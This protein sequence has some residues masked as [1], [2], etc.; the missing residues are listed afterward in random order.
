WLTYVAITTYGYLSLV[1]SRAGLSLVDILTGSEQFRQLF[2]GADGYVAPIGERMVA[3]AGVALSLIGLPIGLYHFWHKF[4]HSAAAWLLAF[5]AVSYFAMLPLRLSSASWETGNRASVYFY[6]GLA[7]VLALAADRLW[8]D[9]QRV[10]TKYVTPMFGSGIAFALIFTIIFAGGV[11]AGRQPQLRL[12]QPFV[13]DAGETLIETQGVSAARWMQETVG[14]NHTI[15]SDEVNGRLMLA[16]AEQAGYVGR[17]PYVR[18]ILR[19]PSF[20]PLQLGVMQ[21]WD[22]EYAVVDRRE[23]AWDNSAGYFFDR[24]DDQGKT[25]AEWSDPLVYGKFD[26]QPLVS[27]IMDTGEVV[28][29]D[30]VDLVDIARRAANDENL[31]AE[32]VSKLMAGNEITPEIVQ[33]LLKQGAISQ[34]TVQE[35]IESG[36][37]NPSQIDPALL[38][39]G[40]DLPQ[41][42]SS[43]K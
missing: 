2:V 16:Q 25:T 24:V 40:I 12:A 14:A 8:A 5:G 38:P 28:I 37:L 1:L 34:E 41:I 30:V 7:F 20:T 33:D 31:P 3:L 4:C 9:S 32:L 18:E 15:V 13:I 23:I 27:R 26:R 21:E 35:M 11:I 29:Y 39:A 10:M 19:T 22:L 43:Q 42:E 6:L 17:F 36:K